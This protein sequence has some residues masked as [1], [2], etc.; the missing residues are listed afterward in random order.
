MLING[1]QEKTDVQ[2][3][4]LV[5]NAKHP[6]ETGISDPSNLKLSLQLL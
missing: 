4:D 3:P 6:P 2:K 5:L 1:I